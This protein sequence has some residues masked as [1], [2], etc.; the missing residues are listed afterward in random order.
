MYEKLLETVLPSQGNYCIFTLKDEKPKFRF[1]E[2]AS[3]DETYEQVEKFKAEEGRNVYFALSSFSGL[4]RKASESIYV[5][6][7]FLDLDV[8][9]PKDSYATKEDAFDGLA[10]FIED[11]GLPEPVVVD[12]GNGVHVYWILKEQVETQKWLPYAE[13]FKKLCY[14]KGLIIDPGV[15]ADAARILRVPGTT[16]YG[17]HYT[18]GDPTKDV[19]LLTDIYTYEFE[20]I[21]SHFG[22]VEVSEKPFNF[23][24][25]RKGLTEE[26]RKL[27]GLDNCE[28]VFQKIAV[29][30]LEGRG[31]NQ[32]K[33]ILE[34]ADTCPEPLWYAGLSVAV[35]CVD[36]DTA[37]H[38]LSEGHPDY[39]PEGT[40]K[41]AQQSLENARWAHS[42]EKFE[43]E[44][45]GG[46]DGCAFKGKIKCP[47]EI[48]K[49]LLIAQP[50]PDAST[51][52][53]ES[54]VDDKF[55]SQYRVFPQAIFP[56]IR[57]AGGGVWYQPP[58]KVKKDG[59]SIQE[60]PYLLFPYDLIPIKR[61][62]S[63]Y[64]GAC[65]HLRVFLPKDGVHDHIMPLSFLGA[66]DKFKDFLFRNNIL[67]SDVRVP[68]MKDYLMKW[69]NYLVNAQKAE[70]MRVQMGWTNNPEYGSF[71]VGTKEITPVGEF[72][73]P[74]S[75][76]TRNVAP[77]LHEKGD[78][79]VWK[80][81]VNN[82]MNS[83]AMRIH[84]LG[85]LVGLGSPI[86]SFSNVGGLVVSLSGPQGSGK[87]GALIGGLSVF[88]EPKKQMIRTMD[89]STEGGLYQRA[90]VLNSIMLGIDETSNFDPKVISNAIYR[91][92]MNE[93]GKLRLQTSYN[94]ERKTMEGS[95]MITLLTTNS[96]NRQKLFETGKADPGGELRRLVE[97]DLLRYRGLFT[98]SEGKGI[99]EPLNHNYGHAGP[100]LIR[101]IYSYGL[102]YVQQRFDYW[103]D[104]LLR[105]FE[106]DTN[107]T[108]WNAGIAACYAG[109]E[110][111]LRAGI[112]DFGI[113][114]HFRDIVENLHAQHKR[115][116]SDKVTYEDIVNDYVLSNMNSLLAINKEKVS[117]EPRSGSLLVRCEVESGKVFI[118]GEPFREYLAKRRVNISEFEVDLMKRGVLLQK[119]VKKRMGSNWK[120]ATGAFNVRAYEFKLDVSDV[121]NDATEEPQ[122]D[123]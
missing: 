32:I 62:I 115:L 40:E 94:N 14:E 12:S 57:P 67:L 68:L 28:Y 96:S 39:T 106:N 103:H 75:T 11:T 20:D 100:E 35:R 121:I 85:V 10:K 50:G 8:G 17:K 80:E 123:N 66:T 13:Q 71:V 76:V 33:W 64:D 109:A 41:K 15:P 112:I 36:G 113:E 7:F 1:I 27:L 97:F 90:S 91:L 5:K 6:S 51:E 117:I 61:L 38:G 119:S 111:A 22:E 102:P 56:F 105:D 110:I 63:P 74:V 23:K 65:L 72:D 87:T 77:L 4:S 93:Q 46:C 101:S 43:S 9:K 69:G 49:R 92:P 47:I 82:I 29:D 81:S 108:Y 107:Y 79:D 88:G 48:G 2:N 73:C 99:F 21:V 118:T 42:C 116:T 53:T 44:N 59:T 30:S 95:K 120:E 84:S 31:C 18:P 70:D 83:K 54:E 60:P 98:D 19:V 114:E 37:I 86:V 122:P 52:A 24:E 55:P 104:R 89:G 78:F 58:P 26:E 34:N 25:V 45:P 3:L 16:N